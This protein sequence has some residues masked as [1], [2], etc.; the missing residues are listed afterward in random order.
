MFSE[1][2]K[3]SMHYLGV[4]P[5]N[6]L[7]WYVSVNISCTAVGELKLRRNTTI[8]NQIASLS[9]QT[10]IQHFLFMTRGFLGGGWGVGIKAKLVVKQKF[11][12]DH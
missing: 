7:I 10:A 11:Q 4:G 1:C 5:Y 8:D 9:K 12:K 2:A 3:H 6:N